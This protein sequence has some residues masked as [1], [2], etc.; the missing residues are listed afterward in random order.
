MPVW[1]KRSASLCVWPSMERSSISSGISF[2]TNRRSNSSAASSAACQPW[3]SL[4]ICLAR[5]TFRSRGFVSPARL[6]VDHAGLDRLGDRGEGL[7]QVLEV[8]NRRGRGGGGVGCFRRVAG[9]LLLSFG[10]AGNVE[11]A[12]Q[13]QA[14]EK[15]ERGADYWETSQRT[16]GRHGH[17]HR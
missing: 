12:G 17:L 1:A 5:F 4:I 8:G 14:G 9:V 2:L 7:A 13:H 15:G 16:S 6:D 10:E 3:K 11:H